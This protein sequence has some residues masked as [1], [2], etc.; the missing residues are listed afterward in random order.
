MRWLALA[1]SSNSGLLRRPLSMLSLGLDYRLFGM[2]PL[3]FKCTNLAIH[4]LNGLLIYSLGRRLV[5]R[6]IPP[7]ITVSLHPDYIALA[8]AALWLLHPLNVSDV[9]Y[10]VQRMNELS[11]LFTLLG[12]LCYAEGR[13]RMCREEPGLLIALIGVC[14][15]GIF[16][17]LSKENGALIMGYALVIE[18]TCFGFSAR[19]KSQESAIKFFFLMMVA[20]PTAILFLY[21]YTYP[22]WLSTSYAGRDFTLPQ[23]L[24]SEARIVWTY[25]LWIALPNPHWM[26][27]FHDDYV[28]S[29]GPFHPWT[30]TASIAGLVLVVVT[31]W[32]LRHK[33]PG[34]AFAVA[35]FL[36][37]HSMESTILPLELI[38]EHRNYLPMAG[39]LLGSLCALSSLVIQKKRQVLRAIVACAVLV[40]LFATLT[41]V[42]THDWGSQLRLALSEVEHHPNSARAQYEAGRA[43]VFDGTAKGQRRQAEDKAVPF[44]ERGKALDSTD[45]YSSSSLILIRGGRGMDV[46]QEIADLARR[47]RDIKQAQINPFLVVMAAAI[48]GK[49]AL[50]RA[51]ME[52]LVDAVF[53]NSRLPPAVRAMVLNNYGHYLFQIVHD[54]QAAIS[55]TL[56]AA[57]QDPKNPLFQ[58]NL[59]RLA[60]ALGDAEEASK[61]LN[62]AI[63]LNK[64][65][66]YDDAIAGLEKQ[67]PAHSQ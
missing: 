58:I 22:Q 10:V 48:E 15:F 61:H 25:L 2:S 9:V 24:F 23:R 49:I 28:I 12:L 1:L 20:L 50:T 41:A 40:L 64:A 18:W 45:I 67:L 27:I 38:F 59:T 52:M 66:M 14:T 47:I 11:T 55:L 29:T 39:L 56:A 36:V 63:Q 42:R 19:S 6:L 43:I 33:N 62:A 35:W 5:P 32:R 30:T 51:Q 21:I 44:F 37:G 65:G 60:L 53:D 31:A 57:A 13:E 8:A 16:A 46:D 54:N 3:A 17:V 4:L 26:G 7:N 34:L